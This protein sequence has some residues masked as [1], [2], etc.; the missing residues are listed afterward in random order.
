MAG[1]RGNNAQQTAPAALTAPIAPPVPLAPVIPA[2]PAPQVPPPN[3]F[4][5]PGQAPALAS[6]PALSTNAPIHYMSKCGLRVYEMSTA[7]LP[8]IY[9]GTPQWLST[10]AQ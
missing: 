9:D 4:N 3:V 1:R 5:N 8:Q 10:Y 2:G 7:P 6:S